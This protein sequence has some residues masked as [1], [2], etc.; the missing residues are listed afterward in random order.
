MPESTAPTSQ[1]LMLS[2][3]WVYQSIYAENR[4][5][6]LLLLLEMAIKLKRAERCKNTPAKRDCRVRLSSLWV[7]DIWYMSLFDPALSQC[8]NAHFGQSKVTKCLELRVVRQSL[9]LLLDSPQIW[10]CTATSP[11]ETTSHTHTHTLPGLTT[12][13]TNEPVVLLVW[14]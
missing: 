2:V 1:S 5:L 4:C 13:C 9:S 3:E 14:Q 7:W 8:K 6:L 10:T 12:G 11:C